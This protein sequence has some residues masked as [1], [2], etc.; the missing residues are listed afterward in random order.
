[1][2]PLAFIALCLFIGCG[3]SS[4]T[5]PATTPT[6]FPPTPPPRESPSPPALSATGVWRS[7]ARDWIIELEHR[8]GV[9]TGRLL[10][11]GKDMYSNPEH[12][13]LQIRGTVNAAG[14]VDFGCVAYQLGFTG[15]VD[16]GGRTM[17]GTTFDCAGRSGCRNYGEIWA[18]Q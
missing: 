13:D 1:M 14:V 18:K 3:S 9:L 15:R 12:A 2:R 17:T 4:P 10:G 7:G 5:T 16:P 6:P 8:N 11:F